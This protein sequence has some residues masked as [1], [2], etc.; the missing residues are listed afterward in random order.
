MRPH[1]KLDENEKKSH[2]IHTHSH[3]NVQKKY[4]NAQDKIWQVTNM[5]THQMSIK[6]GKKES[7]SPVQL[8]I[9]KSMNKV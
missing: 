5:V 6:L 4:A 9:P 3:S 8:S 2:S 1:Y 7:K